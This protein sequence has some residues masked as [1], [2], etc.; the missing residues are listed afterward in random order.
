MFKKLKNRIQFKYRVRKYH[1]NRVPALRGCPQKRGVC[2]RPLIVT[3]KKPNSAKRKVA[4]LRL[5]STRKVMVAYIPGQGHSIKD[6]TVML[7]RG[8]RAR[9]LPAVRYQII[10]G[11]YDVLCVADRFTSRSKYGIK[12]QKREKF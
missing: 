2:I 3:P 8:G 4:K 10:R 9:D 1:K 12:K 6:F 5:S 7:I 11:K